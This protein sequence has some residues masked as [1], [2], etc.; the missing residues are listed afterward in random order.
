MRHSVG[1]RIFELEQWR[2]LRGY[3]A[4]KS[5]LWRWAQPRVTCAVHTLDSHGPC[6]DREGLGARR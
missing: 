4:L 2:A 1:G 3:P 5:E 6:G